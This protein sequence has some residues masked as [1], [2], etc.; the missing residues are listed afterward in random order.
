MDHIIVPEGQEEAFLQAITPPI[1]YNDDWACPNCGGKNV[2]NIGIKGREVHYQIDR[3]WHDET[4]GWKS[5]QHKIAD[6]PFTTIWIRYE[7]WDCDW[8]DTGKSAH[9]LRK[10]HEQT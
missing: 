7:C 9:V 10:K 8:R 3:L 2:V 1:T 6:G 4:W 5:E